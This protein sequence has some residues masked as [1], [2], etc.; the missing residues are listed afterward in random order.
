M[1]QQRHQ[2]VHFIPLDG[3]AKC[4]HCSKVITISN[5]SKEKNKQNTFIAG[6]VMSALLTWNRK[7]HKNKKISKS[8]KFV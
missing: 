2:R 6:V 4:Y 5:F 1:G 3:F 8:L 7:D